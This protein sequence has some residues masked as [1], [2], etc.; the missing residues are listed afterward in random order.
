MYVHLKYVWSPFSLKHFLVWS[1][2]QNHHT[3]LY[4]VSLL[5]DLRSRCQ[6]SMTPEM[7][8]PPLRQCRNVHELCPLALLCNPPR[9]GVFIDAATGFRPFIGLGRYD[10]SQATTHFRASRHFRQPLGSFPGK[11]KPRI[12]FT[13]FRTISAVLLR[14]IRIQNNEANIE[15]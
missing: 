3:T 13:R 4:T 2:F 5:R 7:K 9:H 11:S 15:C 1:A 6:T 8:V 14:R 10:V 12:I